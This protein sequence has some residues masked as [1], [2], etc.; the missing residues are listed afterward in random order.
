MIK[1]N[2]YACTQQVAYLPW[3]WLLGLCGMSCYT[4]SGTIVLADKGALV[5]I[6]ALVHENMADLIISERLLP[7]RYCLWPLDWVI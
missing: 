2:L 6:T 1:V 5:I 4:S 3:L 7:L